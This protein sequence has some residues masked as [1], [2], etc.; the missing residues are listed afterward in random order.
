MIGIIVALE[1]EAKHV[2]SQIEEKKEQKIANKTV[3]T[4]KLF[5]KDCALIISGIGKVNA[6][7]STQILIDKFSP[8]FILNFGTCGGIDKTVNALNYYQVES[9]VQFDFDLRDLDH[10]P[11]GYIQDYRTS[12]FKADTFNICAD[13]EKRKLATADR[14]TESKLDH[15]LILEIQCSLRDMEG[16]AIAQVCM[17][18]DY[19]LV[20][21]KGITDVYGSGLTGEQFY[22]NL[23]KVN[24]GFPSVLENY[25]RKL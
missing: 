5:N 19:P 16:G 1:S 12:Y 17:A 2:V 4:G 18:N 14:F 9:C 15:D 7:L 21:I 13:L 23:T 25:F 6:G 20:M 8:D 3:Y 22:Q 24:L 10:V 11:I